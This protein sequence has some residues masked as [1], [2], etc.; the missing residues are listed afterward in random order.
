MMAEVEI[1]PK[2]MAQAWNHPDIP[3]FL[4]AKADKVAARAKSLAASEDVEM[5]ITTVSGVR[6]KGRAY[7]NVVGDN[8]DQEFGTSRTARRRILGRAGE[9]A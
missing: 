2:L 3:K 1:G 7:V 8:A 9:G 5:N 6:P 4:Q